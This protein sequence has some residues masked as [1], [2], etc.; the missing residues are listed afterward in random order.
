MSILAKT[1]HTNQEI[2]PDYQHFLRNILDK[3][4]SARY[5]MLES[6][7]KQTVA[8]YWE[9]GRAVSEKM[10][11]AGWGKSIVERLAKDLQTE[12]AGVRGFSARN[13]WRMKTFFEHYSSAIKIVENKTNTISA[14]VVAEI[15]GSKKSI[16]LQGNENSATVVAEFLDNETTAISATTVAE[17]QPDE[18]GATAN[19]ATTVAEF[20]MSV[21]QLVADVGWTQNCIILEKCKDLSQ[22]IFYLKQTKAKGWSKF[23]LLERIEKNYF[24]NHALAQNNF[25]ETIPKA[26]KA[27]VAWEFLDDYNIELI[28]PDQPIAEKELEN[29]VVDNI[30]KFLH[31]MG[32]NFAFV[33]RQFKIE[34]GE[35][36]HFIDLLFF[37]FTLNCYVVFELKTTEFSPKDFGQT[38]MYMQLM[39]KH[40]KQP[41]HNSTIG[42][43]VCRAK[44]RLEVEYMLELAKD[45]MGVATYNKYSKLPEEYAQYL[46]SEEDIMKRLLKLLE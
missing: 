6:V 11:A 27:K 18:K 41:Q 38:Q 26:L 44:D 15:L 19:S 28:N 3:I 39:N 42:V 14:T 8:L 30:V 29:A 46:P 12:F 45:P 10:Q 13:I 21:P 40:V 31:E 24:E 16:T 25:D 1:N 35:K 37:N 32:G 33:G 23:D 22:I 20:Q 36:E 2:Q 5:D 17:I 7:S 9:I 43:I 34:L 4:Q